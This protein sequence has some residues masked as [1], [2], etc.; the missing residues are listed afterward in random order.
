MRRNES[1]LGYFLG[2]IA[3]GSLA[4]IFLAPESGADT[5]RYLRRQAVAGADYVKRRTDEISRNAAEA[6][7]HGSRKIQSQMDSLA[8]SVA[9]VCR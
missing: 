2:G 3:M 4:A 1:N 8:K 5:R 7:D 9:A 6:I